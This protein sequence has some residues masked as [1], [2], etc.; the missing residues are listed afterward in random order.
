MGNGWATWSHGY[1]GDVYWT[2]GTQATD[3]LPPGTKAFYL[4]AEPNQFQ[5]LSVEAVA[6]DG[7]TSGPV[8]VQGNSG[9]QYFGFYG[10][11]DKTLASITVTTAD[12]T[13]FGIGEFG[14]NGGVVIG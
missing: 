13:G 9:A 8:N 14:I 3:T 11:G 4:Y 6:Q 7:T 2:T 10:T 1:T 12:P 5:L